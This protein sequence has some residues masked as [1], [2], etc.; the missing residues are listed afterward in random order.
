MSGPC[1]PVARRYRCCLALLALAAAGI[2]GGSRAAT[3]AEVL[4]DKALVVCASADALP[5]SREIGE[6]QGFQIG[7]ARALAADLGVAL[8]VR[9]ARLPREPRLKECDAVV[10]VAVPKGTSTQGD[11]R[12]SRPY[13]AYRP[14]LVVKAPRPVVAALEG[15]APGRIAVES[16]SW[17]HYLLT[18]QGIPVWVRF[19]GDDELMEAVEHGDAEAAIVSS[20]GYSWYLRRHPDS[21]VKAADGPALD[22]ELG[23]DVAVGLLGA[24]QALVDR[25]NDAIERLSQAGVVDAAFAPYG[26]TRILPAAAQR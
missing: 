7:L 17:A 6:P 20:I 10:T 14:L 16:G 23:F 19:R 12:F 9:F 25:V 26:V 8:R 1:M 18:Q 15:F 24:D 3:L 22:E 11:Y 21:R 13:M 2:T 4:R 5:Y